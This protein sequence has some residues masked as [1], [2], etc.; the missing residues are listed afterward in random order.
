MSI[1]HA[2]WN[3]GLISQIVESQRRP[4]PTKSR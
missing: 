2:D 3:V 4:G 1:F